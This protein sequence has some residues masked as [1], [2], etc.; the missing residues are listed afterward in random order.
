MPIIIGIF[1]IL[2][3]LLGLAVEYLVCRFLKKKLWRALPPLVVLILAAL[4]TAGRL[5]VWEADESPVTQLLF[6]PGLP[7]LCALMGTL[8]GWR[9]WK[10]LWGP[11]VI[12]EHRRRD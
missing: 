5:G 7:A 1:C 2:P 6:V 12:W 9:L 3:L 11:R 4:V 10:K 8:L